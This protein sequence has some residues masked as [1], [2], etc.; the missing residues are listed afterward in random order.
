MSE[1]F[2]AQHGIRAALPPAQRVQVGALAQD[3]PPRQVGRWLE[4]VHLWALQHQ[5][6]V[7]VLAANHP[8]RGAGRTLGELD[9]LYRERGRVVHREVAVKFYLAAAPGSSPCSWIGPGKRDR[10]DRKLGRIVDHQARTP[11]LA[12]AHDAWPDTLPSPDVT[13]VLLL[14]MLFSP[15]DAVRLPE[16]ASP[17]APHGRWYFASELAERFGDTPWCV[18]PK[19]WWLSPAHAHAQPTLAA[20]AI[21][22][23]LERPAFIGRVHEHGVERAF[24]VPD[25]WWSSGSL[26]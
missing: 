21:A 25:G 26:P 13:E 3:A 19:P 6:G 5:P 15:C 4:R 16:G 24:V 23:T 1:A 11:A 20:H 12:R 14:G 18:L 7:E 17:Q 22:A 2:W 8:L 9:V 10:L